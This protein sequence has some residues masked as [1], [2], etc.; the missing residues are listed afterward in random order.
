MLE[1]QRK[2]AAMTILATLFDALRRARKQIGRVRLYF[3]IQTYLS[4]GRLIR[5]VGDQGAK[6]CR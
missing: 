1:Y 4:D 5:I 6:S 3:I 2:Q